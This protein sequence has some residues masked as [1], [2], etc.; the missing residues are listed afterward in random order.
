MDILSRNIFVSHFV[1]GMLVLY[2]HNVRSSLTQM[3]NTYY[4]QIVW[5]LSTSILHNM[6]KLCTEFNTSMNNIFMISF[7][8]CCCIS[9]VATIHLEIFTFNKLK[10]AAIYVKI[11]SNCLSCDKN[12][13]TCS[14]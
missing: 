11:V 10:H 14:V 3:S 6:L 9:K 7:L 12:S 5:Q 13:K 8:T 1:I 2:I 4:S